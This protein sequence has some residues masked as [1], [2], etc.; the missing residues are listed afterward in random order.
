[1]KRTPEE[2]LHRVLKVSRLDGWSVAIFAGGCGLASLVFGD[3]VGFSVGLFVALGGALEVRGHH[4]LKH[5][6]AD[7]MRWLVRSQLV[8]LGTIWVY[9]ARQLLSFDLS[10][11][12]EMATP[13]MRTALSEPGLTLDDILPLVRRASYLLWGSVMAVTLIYQ[14]GLALYYRR[15][16]AAV[17]QA[18]TTL[19]A[20]TVPPSA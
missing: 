6:H 8:V 17:V 12:R 11:V 19:P 3:P 13:D 1:M 20:V 7:G 4:L 18:L 16:T 15:R 10:I 14:G 2:I 9:A 5:G